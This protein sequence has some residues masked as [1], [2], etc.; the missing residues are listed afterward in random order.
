MKKAI[1]VI[2]FAIYIASIAIVNFFGLEIAIFDGITYV[3]DIEIT[4]LTVI[5]DGDLESIDSYATRTD[6]DG[7]EVLCYR[8]AYKEKTDEMQANPNM[9]KIEYVIR[10]TNADNKTV[11]FIYAENES[12][13]TFYEDLQTIEFLKS[14]RSVVITLRSTD[15]SNVQKRIE[16][17]CY[18]P[19]N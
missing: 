3:E 19:K 2:I 10:P 5:N 4:E 14:N 9:V 18:R 13:F 8:F 11:D 16:I 7:V 1:I 17:L 12:V 15:G 6:E